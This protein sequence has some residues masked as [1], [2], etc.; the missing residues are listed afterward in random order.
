MLLFIR[1]LK[2][3]GKC[4]EK[5][6]RNTNTDTHSLSL[7]IH[8]CNTTHFSTL[9]VTWLWT[10]LCLRRL[11][12]PHM[13]AR[14]ITIT[15]LLIFFPKYGRACQTSW[16]KANGKLLIKQQSLQHICHW[17]HL[18]QNTLL[19]WYC[20]KLRLD[21]EETYQRKK[22]ILIVLCWVSHYCSLHIV[23]LKSF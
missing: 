8:I 7:Y 4:V 11:F 17:G 1:I 16:G 23:L 12:L 2:Q 20:E 18:C 22:N 14:L 5:R 9:I 15:L 6:P 21:L 10:I 3:S 13:H 19:S